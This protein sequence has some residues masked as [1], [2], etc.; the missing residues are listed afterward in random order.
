ME[1]V[2]LFLYFSIHNGM[3]RITFHCIIMSGMIPFKVLPQWYAEEKSASLKI[4]AEWWC[5]LYIQHFAGY[6]VLKACT[7]NFLLQFLDYTT[8]AK[9]NTSA[10]MKR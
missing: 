9:E 10:I 6:D 7:G 4:Q 1:Y 2:V 3:D 5:V 8:T